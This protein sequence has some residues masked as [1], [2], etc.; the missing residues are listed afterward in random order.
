MSNQRATRTYDSK[1]VGF[2]A[3]NIEV[4]YGSNQV[5]VTEA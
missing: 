3:E 5:K 1:E 2:K 4:I